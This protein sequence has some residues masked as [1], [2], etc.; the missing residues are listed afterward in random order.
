MGRAPCCAKAGLKRG[1]WTA[2]EDQILIKYIQDHGEGSWRSLPRNAGLMRCGKSCRLRWVNYLRT[3][4]KRGNISPQEED[5]IIKL[6]ATLGNRWS[7][8]ASQLPG[9]TDNDIKNH[10]NSYLSRSINVWRR[11]AASDTLPQH[12]LDNLAKLSAKLNNNPSTKKKSNERNVAAIKETGDK[13]IPVNPHDNNDKL[14]TTPD[15]HKQDLLPTRNSWSQKCFESILFLLEDQQ[16]NAEEMEM[17]PLE[18]YIDELVSLSDDMVANTATPQ[19]IFSNEILLSPTAIHLEFM[20]NEDLRSTTSQAEMGSSCRLST[21]Q[22][23]PSLSPSPSPSSLSLSSHFTIDQPLCISGADLNWE[24]YLVDNPDHHDL[25]NHELGSFHNN[26]S[27]LWDDPFHGHDA[28][29]LGL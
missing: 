12:I 28:G 18:N 14:Q 29:S 26:I 6:H 13:Q 2:E 3:D 17:G 10:W 21:Q 19:T 23:Q 5:L 16:D 7:L 8:I 25:M 20:N 9:R 1:R 11:P 27:W 4:L 24:D 22:Q 15:V